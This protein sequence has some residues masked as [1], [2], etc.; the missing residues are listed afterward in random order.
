MIPNDVYNLTIAAN[1]TQACS[2]L[3]LNFALK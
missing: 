3:E 1:M 2:P